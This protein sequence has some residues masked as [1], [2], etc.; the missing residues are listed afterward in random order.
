[1]RE[2]LIKIEPFS[3]VELSQVLIK[4]EVNQHAT[5]CICG[6]VEAE[7]TEDARHL[8]LSERTRVT[9]DVLDEEEKKE[10]LFCGMV[11]E[12]Q[13]EH[14]NFVDYLTL[15]LVDETYLMDVMPHTRVFQEEEKT[16]ED[17]F[18]IITK[19]YNSGGIIT[20][21]K[22]RAKAPELLVQYQETDWEFAK[23]LAARCRSCLVPDTFTV[24]SRYFVRLPERETV[25]LPER[26]EYTIKGGRYPVYI[27]KSR[28]VYD[29]GEELVL[30]R[31]SLFVYKIKTEY[32]SG[33]LWHEY[34]LLNDPEQIGSGMFNPNMA[35]VSLSGSVKKV[36]EDKVQIEI[37]LDEYQTK[38]RRW[39][40][41]STVYSS[42]DGTGWY[43]MPEKGDQIR[44]HFPDQREEQA[45]VISSVHLHT[46]HGRS[47]PDHKS[48]KNKYQKEVLFT[49]EK[50][51]LTDNAGSFIEI[52][53]EEGILIQ[54]D[55]MI[56]IHAKEQ[57][58]IASEDDNVT[59]SAAEMLKLK[60]NET[61]IKLDEDIIFSG[62]EFR[63]Q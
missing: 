46:E 48:L 32:R 41:Y 45:Y 18:Q 8:L 22:A 63:I 30:E 34:S 5:A 49:P 6:I 38:I 33:E 50:L 7:M 47:N 12:Y 23:R 44:L 29:V 26:T 52:S 31:M 56:R 2:M 24:G 54:S 43:C 10:R 19:D 4:K 36:C 15:H 40:P 16:Y 1:M 27:V 3:F 35:G 28:E 37:T 9:I 42:P 53:D 13:M 59:I 61:M 25:T 55:K 57:V 11:K 14:R 60:Q 20:G 62:G 21:T 17:V 39:F 51:V 58:T